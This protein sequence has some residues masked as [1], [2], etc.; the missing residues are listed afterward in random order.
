MKKLGVLVVGMLLLLTALAQAD[1]DPGHPASQIDAGTIA[2]ALTITSSGLIGAG[3]NNA[4]EVTDDLTVKNVL[5]LLPLTSV[6]A[7]C[8][9]GSIYYDSTQKKVYICENANSW[10]EIVTGSIPTLP[11]TTAWDKN[12]TDDLTLTQ[13]TAD[14]FIKIT[15]LPTIP[16]TVAELTDSTNYALTTAIPTLLSTLTNDA[17]YITSADVP[18]TVAE[19]TDSTNYALTTSLHT[20]A[21]SGSYNDLT[22]KP[23]TTDGKDG[24][25]WFSGTDE[26]TVTTAVE[27]DYYLRTDTA[28]VLKK[29]SG[30]TWDNV[31][32]TLNGADSTIPGP[33]PATHINTGGAT[34][35]TN[36]G[37]EIVFYIDANSNSVYDSGE[38]IGTADA[39][40]GSAVSA[41]DIFRGR[42]TGLFTGDINFDPGTGV[43]HGYVGANAACNDAFS[44]SHVCTINDI[45]ETIAYVDL[46]TLTGWTGDAWVI[47]GPPG[48]SGDPSEDCMAFTSGDDTKFGRYWDFDLNGGIGKLT[49]CSTLIPLACCG[50]GN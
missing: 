19:L 39:C 17:N 48:F 30:E 14:G 25:T 31:I 35:C 26:A 16:T 27:G 46:N 36:G 28:Q 11:D 9:E 4:A 41:R 21:T 20:V 32:T 22:N 33:T 18:T 40:T 34:T 8:N 42:T 12:A 29:N 37:D 38:E 24:A 50:G 2:S 5:R 13:I 3:I 1:L 45:F 7:T 15:D 43:L 23:T 10:T 6:P 49:I 47:A 44:G